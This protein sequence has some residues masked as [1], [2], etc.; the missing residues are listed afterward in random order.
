MIEVLLGLALIVAIVTTVVHFWTIWRPILK[1][2][3]I[4]TGCALYAGVTAIIMMQSWPFTEAILADQWPRTQAAA[5]VVPSLAATALIT[6][7]A[8]RIALTGARYLAAPK[9]IPDAFELVAQ[10]AFFLGWVSLLVMGL[11]VANYEVSAWLD[12]P[13]SHAFS[14]NPRPVARLSKN[15]FAE[16][17]PNEVVPAPS[18]FEYA[19]TYYFEA[20]DKR[21][22]QA[23]GWRPSDAQALVD[24]WLKKH[25]VRVVQK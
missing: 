11:N 21:W 3:G 4:V 5:G 2:L 1:W 7:L 8:F 12:R 20:S 19:P 10:L 13:I 23:K 17:G 22:L 6:A 24:D 14:A 16:F 9:L 15:P 18:R 25:P